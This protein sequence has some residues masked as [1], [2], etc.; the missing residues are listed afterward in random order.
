MAT[1]APAWAIDWLVGEIRKR[2]R[3]TLA[4][5][6]AFVSSARS[7]LVLA[8]YLMYF[9][10]CVHQC[11]AVFTELFERHIMSAVFS[12][13]FL[14]LLY[15]VC[16]GTFHWRMTLVHVHVDSGGF[17]VVCERRGHRALMSETRG[18]GIV[19]VS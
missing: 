6:G 19:D 13:H 3:P 4:R 9:M 15:F 16:D 17:H 12:F 14:L 10:D 7:C 2:P 5:T 8:F 18:R 1:A 11:L